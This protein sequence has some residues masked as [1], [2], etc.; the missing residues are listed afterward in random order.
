MNNRLERDK[1]AFGKWLKFGLGIKRW[2]FLAI[3][4]S[5]LFAFSFIAGLEYWQ[6]RRVGAVLEY[7]F[8]KSVYD[9][10]YPGVPYVII[11]AVCLIGLLLLSYSIIVLINKINDILMTSTAKVHD[12]QLI[13][14]IYA[15]LKKRKGVKIVAFGGGTG[16][17]TLLRGIKNITD[18]ITAIVTVSD[19][20]GSSGILRHEFGMIPVGDIRNC[21]TALSNEEMLLTDL[22]SYRFSQGE[23]LSG[24][25]VGNLFITA[26]NEIHNDMEKALDIA[27]R[28]LGCTGRVLPSTNTPVTLKALLEDDTTVTGEVQIVR[29]KQKI[30]KLSTLPQNPHI[31]DTVIEAIEAADVII[32]GPGSLYTSILPHLL[33]PEMVR[34]LSNSGALRIYIANLTTQVGETDDMTIE[35][36]IDVLKE[37]AGENL[38]DMVIVNSQLP[39]ASV[40]AKYREAGSEL[41]MLDG[42]RLDKY[43]E[44]TI[45]KADM[46]TVDSNGYIRHDTRKLAANILRV[47][48]KYKIAQ[49]RQRQG[50]FGQ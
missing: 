14:I 6:K 19:N 42:D 10:Y 13:D 32:F 39:P 38:F 43:P 18:N 26:L 41:L 20:G 22:F 23:G 21:L 9:Y 48:R 16:L 3:F 11:I 29:Q 17:S 40:V 12:D 46:V 24:H 49:Q 33:M 7:I 35:E 8:P 2:L 28:L 44:I 47:Y 30:K 1:I 50:K 45:K 25:S 15:R 34:A 37:H 5:F 36:H 31:T 27:G 4:G